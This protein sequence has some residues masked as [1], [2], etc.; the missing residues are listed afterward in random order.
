M[1][2]TVCILRKHLK[3]SQE[4]FGEMLGVSGAAVSKIESGDRGLTN[5]MFKM[6]CREF[7]ANEEWLRTG[8]GEMFLVEDSTESELAT[9]FAR[10]TKSDND[11]AK[12]FLLTLMKLNQEEWA[13]IERFINGIASVNKKSDHF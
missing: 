8:E 1:I 9:Y 6:I 2:N 4:K 7:N 13:F 11:F 10:V 3:L 12:S 5:T